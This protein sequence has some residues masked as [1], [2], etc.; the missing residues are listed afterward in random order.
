MANPSFIKSFKSGGVIPANSM[1]KFGS[2]DGV[3]EAATAP[4]DGVIGVS[5]L[6]ADAAGDI[7]DVTM[8]G[9]EE[10]KLGGTVGAGDFLTS[11]AASKAISAAAGNRVVGYAT[12][13]GVS[14]D[15]IGVFISPSKI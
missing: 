13:S 5:V 15:I 7:I 12:E 10:V 6:G 11:D 14:G 1:I 9:I 4:T 8:G 3:V 2:T